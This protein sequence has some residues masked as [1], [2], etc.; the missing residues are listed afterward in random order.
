MNKKNVGKRVLSGIR[1][2]DFTDA[3]AGPFCARYLADCGCEVINIERPEGKI[4]RYLPYSQDGFCSEYIQNHCGKKSL[5]MDLKADGARELV[6]E[7]A[8]VSDVVLENYRPGVMKDFGLSYE[9]F[10]AVNPGIVMCSISGWGQ[11]GPEREFMGIDSV[12]QASRGLMYLSSG[13]EERPV[14]VSFAVSDILA[15]LNGFG[16]ICAA[17]FRRNVTG[18]GDYIDIGM[19]DCLLTALGNSVGAHILSKGKA[20]FRYMQGSYSP[21]LSPA[22]AYK[23]KDGYIVIYARQDLGWQR[24]AEL[25]G[26]P[27]L[28]NDPKYATHADRIK[29]KQKVTKLIDDWV[30][31]FDHV[32]D[33][34]ALLQSYRIIAAPVLKLSHVVDGDAQTKARGMIVN[35]PHPALGDFR[36]LNTPMRFTNAKAQV[37]EPPPVDVGEHTNQVLKGTLKLTARQIKELKDKKIVFGPDK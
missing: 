5:A 29:N 8:K 32:A 3:M 22:G 4:A 28:G 27:E 17:L 21:D 9:D 11:T 13:P 26:K 1:V 10:K 20:D 35:M 31:T 33:V 25:M 2:L 30:Q 15:G 23:G 19:G 6:L 24:I 16:A 18:E 12:V 34:A 7:M 36:Y 14:F 37:E